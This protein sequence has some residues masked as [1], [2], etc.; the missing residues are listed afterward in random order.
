MN[1]LLHNFRYALSE[2]GD[3]GMLVAADAFQEA[4]VTDNDKP[5]QFSELL[6]KYVEI[7]TCVRMSQVPPL[8]LAKRYD[9]LNKGFGAKPTKVVNGATYSK[10]FGPLYTALEVDQATL[11]GNIGLLAEEPVREL[12]IRYATPS[13]DLAMI[14]RNYRIE[15][16]HMLS[17]AATYNYGNGRNSIAWNLAQ[18]IKDITAPQLMRLSITNVVDPKKHLQLFFQMSKVAKGCELW[19]SPNTYSAAVHVCSKR[20]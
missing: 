17:I 2:G 10:P 20:L 16:M 11:I 12:S 5:A 1:D 8:A 14:L 18:S 19:V 13:N 15:T 9:E 6:R 3:T 4:S 7:Q